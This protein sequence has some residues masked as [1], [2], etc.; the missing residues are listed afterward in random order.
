MLFKNGYENLHTKKE[1]VID[2]VML[3]SLSEIKDL[4]GLFVVLRYS[5]PRAGATLFP[6]ILFV[7]FRILVNVKSFLEYFKCY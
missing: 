3:L 1:G 7:V 5:I 2:G 6:F 4:M